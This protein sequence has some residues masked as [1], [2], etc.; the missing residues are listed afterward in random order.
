V[1]QDQRSGDIEIEFGGK[2]SQRDVSRLSNTSDGSGR[3]VQSQSSNGSGTLPEDTQRQQQLQL[4]GTGGASVQ[5]LKEKYLDDRIANFDPKKR[6]SKEVH[7][8]AAPIPQEQASLKNTAAP[9]AKATKATR[10]EKDLSSSLSSSSSGGEGDTSHQE[11][12]LED[13]AAQETVKEKIVPLS[14]PRKR[15]VASSSSETSALKASAATAVAAAAPTPAPTAPAGPLVDNEVDI[16]DK[17]RVVRRPAVPPVAPTAAAA[18]GGASAGCSHF[19]NAFREISVNQRSYLQL[20][21]IL[22]KGASSSVCR[23]LALNQHNTNTTNQNHTSQPRSGVEIYAFKRIEI[24]NSAPEDIEEAF[25][26]YANEINLLKQCRGCPYIINLIDYEVNRQE[27]CVSMVLELGEIDLANAINHY[28]KITTSSS[29]SSLLHHH[30][31]HLPSSKVNPYFLRMVWERMLLAVD[32][33]H[34]HR[35]VHGDLKPANFVFVQGQLKL[36]DFGISRE[37]SNDTTNIVRSGLMGTI[38]YMAPEAVMPQYLPLTDEEYHG[39]HGAHGAP[40][41]PGNEDDNDDSP[42]PQQQRQTQM[43]KHGRASDV[44]SLGCILYQMLYGKTPFATVR[45]LQQK[46]ALITNKEAVIQFPPLAE[47]LGVD[48][49]KKCLVREISERATIRGEHGL[50]NHPFLTAHLQ[51]TCDQGTNTTG[52]GAGTGT[53]AGAAEAQGPGDGSSGK[54]RSSSRERRMAVSEEEQRESERQERC[55]KGITRVQVSAPTPPCLL[56]PSPDQTPCAECP[57]S[58]AGGQR[59]DRREGSLV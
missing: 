20:D 27:M 23:V 54:S 14:P 50:L 13:Y 7:F 52:A 5:K 2:R 55:N 16:S 28:K 11:T 6:R 33:I 38:N 30:Q 32:F 56:I 24:K 19:M 59:G 48:V 43:I 51:P 21:G 12:Q 8:A 35:I 31:N 45:N 3:S 40:G 29:S 44:W 26:S 34:E 41:G 22:G 17:L 10:D 57:G 42:H 58:L 53:E 47:T 9:A 49:A 1:T 4:Q 46:L 37:I 39:A 18:G 36:I 25:A 15:R